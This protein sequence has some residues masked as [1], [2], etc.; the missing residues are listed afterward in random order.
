LNAEGGVSEP[1]ELE[2]VQVHA[3]VLFLSKILDILKGRLQHC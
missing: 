2:A 3:V 1:G